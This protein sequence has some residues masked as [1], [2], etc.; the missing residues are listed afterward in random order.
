MEAFD[1]ALLR[2]RGALDVVMRYGFRGHSSGGKN[3][4]FYQRSKDQRL[5]RRTDDLLHIRERVV[6]HHLGVG[7]T[8]LGLLKRV[9]VVWH[10][11]SGERIVGAWNEEDRR[12]LLLG[13]ASY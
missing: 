9:K 6:L 4:I 11:P 7:P 5:M 3:G 10:S 2:I 12:L 13:F 8:E 1:R